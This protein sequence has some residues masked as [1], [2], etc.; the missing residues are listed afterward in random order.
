MSGR[1]CTITI[2]FLHKLGNNE[3]DEEISLPVAL[4]SPLEVLKEQLEAYSGIPNDQQ[5]LILLDLS[6]AER[7]NDILLEGKD[8]VSLR[9]C[10]IRGGS[11]LTL[12]PLGMAA[13]AS[14]SRRDRQALAM[15]QQQMI[16]VAASAQAALMSEECRLD[17]RVSAAQADHSYNG[18]IFD[19]M[20]KSTEDVY[21][22]SIWLGG[23]LGRIVSSSYFRYYL[24]LILFYV[25]LRIC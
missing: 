3:E 12:H 23:M 19:I 20:N 24:I 9:G 22:T 1:G 8:E 6:D 4:H 18:I 14:C 7:N 2:Q 10:G 25:F 17:T 11:V 16:R 15:K 13:E 5:V 21:V